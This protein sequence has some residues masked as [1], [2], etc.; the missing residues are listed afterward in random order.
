MNTRIG[1]LITVVATPLI[2]LPA[3]A[4]DKDVKTDVN[5]NSPKTSQTSSALKERLGT[6]TKASEVIGM[7]IQNAQN[8][9]VGKVEELAVDLQPGRIV[10]VIIS[11]DGKSIAVPPRAFTVDATSKALRLDVPQEKVKGAPAFES[12]YYGDSNRVGEIYR[13]YGQQP[14]SDEARPR[15]ISREYASAGTQLEK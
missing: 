15:G 9:K 11:A 10:Y 6:V 8:E 5:R 4:A 3:I 7:E 2:A 1:F 13:Y 14:Y 12:S